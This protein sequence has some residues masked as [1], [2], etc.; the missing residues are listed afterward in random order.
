MNA[1]AWLFPHAAPTG[2]IR[3][4]RD[5]LNATLRRQQEALSPKVLRRTLAELQ[6]I[7]DPQI[8]EVE[9]GR[10]AKGVAAWYAGATPEQRRDCW[11]LMSEQFIADPQKVSAAQAQYAAAAGTPDE[12]VAQVRLRR[13]TVSPRRRLLQR[14]SVLPEGIRFLVDMRA[15]MRDVKC[16]RFSPLDGE[17]EARN[18][19]AAARSI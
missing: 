10:R 11:L 15:E 2:G 6:S 18:S 17:P 14:F 1:L 5:R 12:A 13:A 16:S 3:S 4:T 7:I 8:S 19:S 9:G